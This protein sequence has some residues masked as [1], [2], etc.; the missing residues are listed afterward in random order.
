MSK[1]IIG[2]ILFGVVLMPTFA[3]TPY[4]IEKKKAKANRQKVEA[5]KKDAYWKDAPFAVATVN[6]LSGIRR[7]PDLF[8][9]DGDFTKPL[10]VMAAQNEYEGASVLLYGFQNSK[11]VLL[12]ANPLR[13]PGGAV[14]PAANVDIKIVKVWYQQGTAWGGFFSD[15][16]RRIATPELMVYDEALLHV[17]HENKENFLRRDTKNGS[18]YQWIS[19]NG[20]VVDHRYEPATAVVNSQIHDASSLQPFTVNENEF[21]QLIL[22]YMIPDGQKP[23]IY[24]G[25]VDALVAGKKVCDI[26]VEVHVLPFTLPEPKTFYHAE[27]PFMVTPYMGRISVYKSEK[28]ARNMVRHNVKNC[29]LGNIKTKA[30]AEEAYAMFKK[31]G[32]D[33]K[34]LFCALPGCGMTT[35][36]PPDESNVNYAKFVAA[37]NDIAASIE[38]IR[39][40][41]GKDVKAYS[42]GI[43]EGSAGTVRRERAT[44]QGVHR[45]GGNTIVATRWHPYILFNLD[46]ANVPRHP[47]AYKKAEADAFHASNPDGIIGWYADP[48]SGPENPDYTRRL[49]GWQT[50][51]N[52]YD[53]ICQYIL[54]R[55][56]WNDFWI[57]AEPF[58][59]GL[60]LVYPQDNDILDTIEWEG[61]REGLD[62]VRYGTLLKTLCE[63]GRTSQNVDTAYAARAALTWVSQVDCEHSELDYLRLEMISRILDLQSRLAKEGK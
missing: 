15:P 51:R 55:D 28:L 27:K 57:P 7:T 61:L 10:S 25:T 5:F 26:P 9:E 40:V 44:W 48:H 12:K 22:T 30:Q 14:L 42:Y 59:R 47:R 33:T 56:N 6:P 8:P 36:Y 60:M 4:P 38:I 62:D 13:G 52:N 19:F 11:D 20:A 31:T 37:T 16:L 45:A 53:A 43:D 23:G 3:D 34:Q 17:D 50:W 24:K 41:F 18:D 58:L 63:K 1:N 35:D 21:K 29:L 32:F 46:Y 2:A 49:Y 39:D 54:F